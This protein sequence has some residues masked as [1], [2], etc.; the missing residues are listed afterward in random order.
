[1]RPSIHVLPS[2]TFRRTT[3]G[4]RSCTVPA[5][6]TNDQRRP[7]GG[8]S[9]K[10]IAKLLCH[11]H[12]WYAPLD[13]LHGVLRRIVSGKVIRKTFPLKLFYRLVYCTYIYIYRIYISR[14]VRAFC[15]E[16]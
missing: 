11:S 4:A 8:K 12:P 13:Y 3:S 10:T 1:M 15:W 7:V 2:K 14:K 9:L 16:N 6:D 5:A